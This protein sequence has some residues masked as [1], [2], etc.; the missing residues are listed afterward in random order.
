MRAAQT[1]E[2][3][4]GHNGELK[5]PP[6]ALE[7]KVCYRSSE[8]IGSSRVC[9]GKLLEASGVCLVCYLIWDAAGA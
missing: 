4:H 1:A 6:G 3:I 2:G 7:K 8:G 5:L 9:R